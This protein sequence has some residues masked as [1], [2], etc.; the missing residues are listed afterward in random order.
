MSDWV[1]P[2]PGDSEWESVQH[3]TLTLACRAQE[4]PNCPLPQHCHC[5]C[6][7]HEQARQ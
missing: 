3:D 1:I 5:H 6:Q 7:C 2:D 4:H